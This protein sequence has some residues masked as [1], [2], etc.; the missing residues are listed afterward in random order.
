M[1]SREGCVPSCHPNSTRSTSGISCRA[2][3]TLPPKAILLDCLC[4]GSSSVPPAC[5]P[6]GPRLTAP[7]VAVGGHV[8]QP[9]AR[10]SQQLDP[11]GPQRCTEA[12][13]LQQSPLVLWEGRGQ[14]PA[15][16]CLVL[17][18][19]WAQRGAVTHPVPTCMQRHGGLG[20]L[21]NTQGHAGFSL[22]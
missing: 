4:A 2:H 10:N 3:T 12:A 19:G 17:R 14:A 21:Q 18:A 9:A 15:P 11:R 8:Q 6:A 7:H 22:P 5:V 16:A 20:R 1:L 13:S